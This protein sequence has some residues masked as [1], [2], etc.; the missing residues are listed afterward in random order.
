MRE[1][2]QLPHQPAC[3][4]SFNVIELDKGVRV[5]EVSSETPTFGPQPWLALKTVSGTYHHD[6]FDID[7]PHYSWKYVFD[8]ETFPIEAI[9]AIGVAGS[10]AFGITT[11]QVYDVK[12][13]RLQ[14][15][16]LNQKIL[17]QPAS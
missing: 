14:T 15:R 9:E 16:V 11:V 8:D 5:L 13:D 3:E 4:L 2:L 7:T 1:A 12:Q 6:N 10:N 17:N